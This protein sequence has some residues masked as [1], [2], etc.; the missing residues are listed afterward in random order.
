MEVSRIHK[1]ARKTQELHTSHC[2]YISISDKSHTELSFASIGDKAP[3]VLS[4]I[5]RD[6][7]LLQAIQR[8]GS[9]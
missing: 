6:K 7:L 1:T 5:S 2:T 9:E 3:A 8:K 4:D